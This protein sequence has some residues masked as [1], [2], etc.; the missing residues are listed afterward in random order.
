[1]S[2]DRQF[3]E[4]IRDELD[5]AVEAHPPALQGRLRA[6]RREALS[7]A[8]RHATPR[9]WIPAVA[10]SLFAVVAITSLWMP[11]AGQPDSTTEALLQAA[12]DVDM[13]MLKA[14]DDIEFY[15][16]LEFYYW[17]EQEQAGAG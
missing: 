3:L 8:A 12:S 5:A 2:D 4:R 15:Q 7:A 11:P 9:L 13:Q 14:G 16:N 6:A 17:L 1:M 10:A